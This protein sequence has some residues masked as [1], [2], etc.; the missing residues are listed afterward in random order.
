VLK[1]CRGNASPFALAVLL[2]FFSIC[3]AA[4]PAI[5]PQWRGPTRDG[6]VGGAAWPE[7]LKE[8]DLVQ[9]W[10]I[11]LEPS[12]SGPIVSADRVFT[13]ETRDK[14]EEVVTALDRQTGKVIWQARWPGAMEVPFFARANGSW[15]RSTPAYDGERLYVAGIRDVLVC[16][17]AADG[18]E[19]WRVDFVGKYGSPLPAFGF[20]CSPLVF[21]NDLFVQAGSSCF[22]LDKLTGN[23]RWRSLNDA[24]G[25]MGSAFSS[26][27]LAEVAGKRQLLVQAREKL[28]GLEPDTGRVLWEQPVQATRGMNILT[29]IAFENGV[30]TSAY[31]G[32]TLRFNLDQSE[33]EATKVTAAWTRNVEGYMSTPVVVGDHAYLHLRNQRVTCINL[34][35]G[36]QTWTTDR[37]YGKYW[38]M[39]TNGDKILALDERGILLLF[40][41]N[42]EKFELFDT[43]KIAANESWA[44][45]AIAGDELFIRD[46]KG[47]TAYRWKVR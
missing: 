20:V 30:F 40:K 45:L 25:M 24:G 26:P 4:D 9:T 28:A 38:S 8:A 19:V 47:L 2:T 23:E 7:S 11:D 41:A 21:G 18:K 22:C 14:S 37:S 42:P 46:L 17:N 29:P 33:G 3:S 16:L 1:R 34:K 13:T 27:V 5:W 10:H 36:Q 32:K 31:G 6:H 43:R 15:I 44:H 12:Y 35:T 39:V